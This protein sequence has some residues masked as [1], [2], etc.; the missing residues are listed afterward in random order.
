MRS[1]CQYEP[2][3]LWSR[4]HFTKNIFNGIILKLRSSKSR[5]Y[6]FWFQQSIDFDLFLFFFNCSTY[7]LLLG[8]FLELHWVNRITMFTHFNRLLILIC[9]YSSSI[10]VLVKSFTTINLHCARSILCRIESESTR[11]PTSPYPCEL[12]AII[13]FIAKAV[14]H[15][16][17]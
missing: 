5:N 11:R 1:F 4:Q 9:Y 17:D 2:Y 15:N 10:E 7:L 14:P 16:D 6:V 13:R 8:L 3:E 12:I